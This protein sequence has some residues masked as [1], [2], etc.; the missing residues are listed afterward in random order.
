MQTSRTRLHALSRRL[1]DALERLNVYTPNRS[2]FPIVELPLRDH[3]RIAD[4]GRL[5]FDRGV[6]V[7]LA[8][9]PLVPK[10]EVGF[11]AQLTAANTE[12]E[13]DALIAAIEELADAG[14]LQVREA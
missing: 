11:R 9:F 13:V 5:L 3:E 1:L 14:E 10:N 12:A 8:A 7:T 6:Y 2:G 4:V